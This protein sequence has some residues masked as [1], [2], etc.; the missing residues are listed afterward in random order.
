MFTIENSKNQKIN[1]LDSN[2]SEHKFNVYQQFYIVGLDPN[3]MFNINKIDLQSYPEPYTSPKI[4]SKYPPNDLFYINIPDNIVALHCFPKGIK[5]IIIEYNKSNYDEKIKTQNSFIFSLENQY[6]VDK[7]SSLKTNRLYFSCLLFYEN[8]ENYR[9]CTAYRNNIYN[10]YYIDLN[11]G[12]AEVKNKGLLI[13]KVIC[14]SSFSPFFE[15]SQKVLESLKKYV[16]NFIYNKYNCNLYPIEKIIEGLIFNLPAIPRANFVLKLNK[17]TFEPSFIDKEEEEDD[18]EEENSI[19][20]RSKNK[21]QN[22]ENNKSDEIIFYESPFNRQ[23]KNVINYSILMRYFRIKEIFEI[24][25]YILLEEPILFFSEDIQA[26]TN[27]IEGLISLIY[28]LEYQYPVMSVLPEKNYSFIS[29]FKHFIFG[30]NYKYSDDIFVNKG[31]NLEDKKYIII[32]KI[33]KR[34]KNILNNEEEDKIKYSV[35]TSIATDSSKPLVK[36]EQDKINDID[37]I[38]KYNKAETEN[39]QDKRKLM[40][41]MH[42]LEKCAKRLE[43]STQDKIKELYNKSKN[44][45]N[46]NLKE[47]EN[48]FNDEIRKTFIYFFSC[49]LLKYQSFCVK[50]E[51]NLEV[52]GYHT[53][54]SDNNN[55]LESTLIT[56]NKINCSSF[57]EKDFGYFLERNPKLE[58]KYL[59]NKLKIK[60]IF[61]CKEFIED[62]DTPK[63]D[64]P[65]YRKFF[66]TQ[67]FFYFIKKKI[68]PNSTQDKLDILYFDNKVNEKINRS[69]R[70][71]K[72]ET[73]YFNDELVN[74]TCEIIINSFKKAASKDLNKFLRENIKNCH[75]G[76]NYFQIIKRENKLFSNISNNKNKNNNE[77]QNLEFE[78]NEGFC[79]SLNKTD[80]IGTNIDLY[81]TTL[82]TTAKMSIKDDNDDDEENTK[83]KYTFSYYVFPKLLNDDCF[84]KKENIL[85]EEYGNDNF[86]QNNKNDFN[87]KN[88]NCLYNQFEKQANIFIKK[89]L[90]KQ[91]YK[92]YDYNLNIKWKYK[93]KY[94]ECISKLWLLY[95]AKTFHCIA[96]SKKRYY[97]D[98]VLMFLNDKN[99]NV[100]QDTIILLF[101]SINKFGDKSMNQELFMYLKKKKYINFLCLREKTN[102]GNNFAKY[103]N[104]KTKNN[105]LFES[106][107]DSMYLNQDNSSRFRN[108]DWEYRER[109][110]QRKKRKLFDFYI[111]SYCSPN[112]NENIDIDLKEENLI[113]LDQEIENKENTNICGETLIFNLKDLFNCETNKKYIEIECPKCQKNQ[114]ITMTCFYNDDNNINRYQFNFN[115]VSPLALQKEN[116]FKNYNILDPLTISKEH[117]EEYLSALFY[118]Y[119][120]GLPCNFLIPRGVSDD[121]LIEE[122]GGTYNNLDPI[123]EILSNP[124]AYLHKKSMCH[125]RTP[126]LRKRANSKERQ[127]TSFGRNRSPQSSRKSPSP[128]KS[129][130]TK[131]SKFAP[132]ANNNINTNNN[133]DDNK[134]NSDGKMKT[135]KTKIVT[136]SCFKK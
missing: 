90:I 92:I 13:P 63:L 104:I 24:I 131:K 59:L 106:I 65:F 60:D 73:K 105:S 19:I 66:D 86:W 8:V 109:I 112:L 108:F 50:Y 39:I 12:L 58:E 134:N 1:E 35:I 41:P 18:D 76:I 55:F 132:Q 30:I 115:L 47:K 71:L 85:W 15:Q 33:E 5:D 87:L 111:Y 127:N 72:I 129:S 22:I 102:S 93:Y 46:I 68:F 124:A 125:L 11:N 26:L 120:Q 48:I 99:N 29:L 38:H 45:K 31:I 116:W 54:K 128:I 16:D 36:I 69:S 28:P 101:N 61:N 67:I 37:N 64:R 78:K 32:I 122:R 2:L 3:L 94:E 107:R 17:E 100:D 81:S 56:N 84:Y 57:E 118:F 89:P 97:F 34:F 110:N 43:K 80:T 103:I 82:N 83:N 23:P 114:Y 121:E 75:K 88:C 62:N 96:F 133:N 91:N 7:S 130:F 119:D 9:D 42:Y 52:I 70:K 40:L 27:I 14:L 49:I 6:P 10:N 126:R 98:E 123:E 79:I 74:L 136:F 77:N 117:Q 51:N 21:I 135:Y 4:I 20:N 53:S 95:L 44:K 25:K 113:N